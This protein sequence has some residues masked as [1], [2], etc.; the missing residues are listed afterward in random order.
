M[1]RTNWK[2]AAVTAEPLGQ[3]TQSPLEEPATQGPEYSLFPVLL[4]RRFHPS[5]LASIVSLRRSFRGGLERVPLTAAAV[6]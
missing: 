4:P 2:Q 6:H 1:V 3:A 5:Q